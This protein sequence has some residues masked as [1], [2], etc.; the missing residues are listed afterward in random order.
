MKM[1]KK[2]VLIL[3]TFVLGWGCSDTNN[4]TTGQ[5]SL[6]LTDAPFPTD[7]VAEANVTISKIEVRKS[8]EDEESKFIVL[9]E[10]TVQFNLLDLTNGVTASLVDL[11]IEVGY[12]D[13]VRL[14]VSKANVVLAG[15]IITYELTIPSGAQ[16]GIKVF[17]DPSIEVA[18][19]LTTEL[20]LD[21][22]VSRSFVVQGNPD[23]PAGVNGFIFKP[24]IKAA[25]LSTS[26]SLYGTVSDTIGTAEGAIIS[27]YAADT[28]NTSTLSDETG[29][30]TI[31]GLAAGTYDVMTSYGEYTTVTNE[32]VVITAGNETNLDI[33][34]T[35]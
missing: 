27:V 14:Y 23:T 21:F 5:L 25:N 16:T 30:Y 11:D 35:E 9:S 15:G 3:M 6:K 7:L 31:M 17:I 10:D 18:G 4:E 19:G 22:D 13:L 34:L 1:I 33:Q 20:L 26:G 2:T 32:E 12:Y 24:T 29:S 8:G 28:L